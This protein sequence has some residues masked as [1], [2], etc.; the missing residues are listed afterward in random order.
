LESVGK[1][2]S[3]VTDDT[4]EAA[5]LLDGKSNSG[6]GATPA[7]GGCPPVDIPTPG[8]EPMV[9]PPNIQKKLDENSDRQK[10]NYLQQKK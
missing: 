9:L 5:A 2:A 4:P 1:P 3:I 7:A 6:I 8:T 10:K